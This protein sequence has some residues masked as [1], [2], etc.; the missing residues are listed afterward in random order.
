MP[1]QQQSRGADSLDKGAM[2]IMKSLPGSRTFTFQTFAGLRNFPGV[3]NSFEES[4]RPF[5]AVIIKFVTCCCFRRP[6]RSYGVLFVPCLFL[7]PICNRIEPACI[8]RLSD[9]GDVRK[10][11]TRVRASINLGFPSRRA[12]ARDFGHQKRPKVG[13]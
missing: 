12:S 13:S 3:R 2:F 1:V 9:F 11:G 4:L 7:N 5:R 8:F 6:E 10:L